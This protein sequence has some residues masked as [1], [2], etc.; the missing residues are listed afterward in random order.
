MIS[1]LIFEDY[2]SL[3]LSCKLEIELTYPCVQVKAKTISE[4][5]TEA[6]RKLGLR[7]GTTRLQTN[8]TP[9]VV[10]QGTNK[11]V[12]NYLNPTDNKT[13]RPLSGDDVWRSKTLSNSIPGQNLRSSSKPNPTQ[14]TVSTSILPPVLLQATASTSMA[15]PASKASLLP[16]G[17]WSSRI[18]SKQL[19]FPIK[20]SALLISNEKEEKLFLPPGGTSSLIS[21]SS[22][23]QE[24]PKQIQDSSSARTERQ[25]EKLT[26]HD[27]ERKTQSLL[28]EYFHVRDL[29]EAR[30]C[31]QD[32]DSPGYH[33]QFLFRAIS[34]ALEQKELHVQMVGELIDHLF[35]Q[36]T[37]SK[38]DIRDGFL[39]IAEQYDDF[40]IDVPL[41]PKYIGRLFGKSA[42]TGTVDLRLLSDFLTKIEDI[43]SRKEILDT[44]L[45]TIK[46]DPRG[47]QLLYVQEA[48]LSNCEKLT[49]E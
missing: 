14:P 45:T 8:D 42:L 46:S 29:N 30:Q 31:V 48:E 17:K 24:K 3:I 23:K 15:L 32:L 20:T 34:T 9:R 35:S 33:A 28:K 25:A 40:A 39:L 13:M 43:E 22:E 37:V 10:M 44:A 18:F 21:S 1:I 47:K 19:P 5:H 16:Q 4:I 11:P 41:A 38:V 36:Q 49:Q 27:L 6:E 12:Q 2:K 26:A 7:P